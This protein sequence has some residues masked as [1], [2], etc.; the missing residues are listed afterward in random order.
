MNLL[1]GPPGRLPTEMSSHGA[2]Q[3]PDW[4]QKACKTGIENK[5]DRLHKRPGYDENDFRRRG[6]S[7]FEQRNS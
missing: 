4:E 7:E 1:L 6:S 2:S 5:W 3:P